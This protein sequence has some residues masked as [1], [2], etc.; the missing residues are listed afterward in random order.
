MREKK[1][2]PFNAEMDAPSK[3]LARLAVY[4]EVHQLLV[5]SSRWRVGAPRVLILPGRKP[6][7][8]I[9][10]AK[11][12]LGAHVTAIDTDEKA[13]AAARDGGA[14][15]AR[16]FD[17][18][19]LR[20][21]GYSE[22]PNL[23][24]VT[25]FDFVNLDLCGLVTT[26]GAAQAFERAAKVGAHVATWFSFGHE[27]AMSAIGMEAA[28]QL[29]CP[30]VSDPFHDVPSTIKNRTLFIW[31]RALMGGPGF[32]SGAVSRF[33]VHKVWSYKSNAMPMFVAL[34]T[35]RSCRG[36]YRIPF[37]RIT[38]KGYRDEVLRVADAEGAD[39][40]AMLYGCSKAQIAAWKAVRTT[41]QREW[42]GRRSRKA[43][44]QL[45]LTE[46]AA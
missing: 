24:E 5:D 12:L 7:H 8:E 6:A 27:A 36:P 45:V 39:R 2:T 17:L 30:G 31:K 37:E 4:R 25:S 26:P 9:G 11:H 29:G 42:A 46:R 35:D 28:F 40:A 10:L 13:V 23:H 1:P 44:G 19:T 38:G 18:S 20:L 15:R 14:D 43:D 34:W 3:R 22:T 32:G 33:A 21:S 41:Q 16:L